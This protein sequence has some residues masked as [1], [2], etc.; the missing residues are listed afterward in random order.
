MCCGSFRIQQVCSCR[1][2]H[3][4]S[5]FC[6]SVWSSFGLPQRIY[7][8]NATL[9]GLVQDAAFIADGMCCSYVFS[10]SVGQVPV[11]HMS[12]SAF[13]QISPSEL[14]TQPVCLTMAQAVLQLVGRVGCVNMGDAFVFEH[15]AACVA[16]CYVLALAERL[17]QVCSCR[18]ARHTVFVLRKCLELLCFTATDLPCECDNVQ[19]AAFTAVLHLMLPMLCDA[20][21]PAMAY[22]VLNTSYQV[23]K[24]SLFVGVLC[25]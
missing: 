21:R 12:V 9:H 20:S 19:D 24:A 22:R 10:G 14:A 11:W 3:H 7:L 13:E 16:A 25:F 18:P 23:S 6:A 8:A 2:A 4:P 15:G 1:P 17:K 5:S